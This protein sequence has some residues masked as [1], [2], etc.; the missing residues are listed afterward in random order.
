LDSDAEE[1]RDMRQDLATYEIR[2]IRVA[3]I[4]VYRARDEIC[5]RAPVG[6]GGGYVTVTGAHGIVEAADDARILQAHQ[7]AEIV[8]ADG[9]PL[10][11]LGRV[12]GYRDIGRVNGPELME[13]IFANED[14]RKLGH[15]FYGGNPAAVTNLRTVLVS[16]FGD[17][18]M[19]GTY[20]PPIKPIGFEEDEDVIARIRALRPDLV[21]VGLSTPKQEVWMQMHMHKIGCGIG[22]GVGAA[23]DLLSGTTRRAPRWV[24]RSCFEWLFRL[25]VEPR[26]LYK[27]YFYVIPRFMYFWVEA[28]IKGSQNAA[29][30]SAKSR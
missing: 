24:Q 7:N 8:V 13:L 15:F 10:V 2:G 29:Y 3:A 19:I 27:R 23:F 25:M 21:W 28:A 1:P 17:F 26:R 14:Y 4:D 18:N 12:L 16:R 11:V 30:T 6:K 22:V 20:S 9:M 5:A